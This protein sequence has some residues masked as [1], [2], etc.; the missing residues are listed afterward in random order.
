MLTFAERGGLLKVLLLVGF[1]IALTISAR[2]S[3]AARD[4][5]LILHAASVVYNNRVSLHA[6]V[7]REMLLRI[8]INASDMT[9]F[10]FIHARLC[11][12]LVAFVVDWRHA[13]LLGMVQI[14][15]RRV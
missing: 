7:V 3:D 8:A 10:V 2:Q 9:H 1:L 12:L 13:K 5:V 6:L 4:L 14:E 15:H 11:L